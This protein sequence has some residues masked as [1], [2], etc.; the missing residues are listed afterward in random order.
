[1]S[2]G[3]AQAPDGQRAT[4]ITVWNDIRDP[5][6]VV[7]ELF[8][9]FGADRIR[10]VSGNWSVLGGTMMLAGIPV[11]PS[12]IDV[13]E[14]YAA[15]LKEENAVPTPF[16]SVERLLHALWLMLDQ[17]I[18]NT[19]EEH[20]RP[21]HSHR[22][23]KMNLPTMVTIIDLRR[24]EGYKPADGESHTE[25]SHRWVTRG[26]WR[27]QPCGVGRTERKRIW[28]NDFIKGPEGKPL[29]ISQKVYALR[30]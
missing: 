28:I 4:F 30:R 6:S 11:G 2:W 12:R 15:Q 16:T 8:K 10:Q 7:L 1:M 25:W 24:L 21:K 19:R 22:A 20:V 26:H 13:P 23:R 14:D 27:W 18:V 3:P 5:D 9:Q 17:T 29:V